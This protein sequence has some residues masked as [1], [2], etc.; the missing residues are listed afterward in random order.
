MSCSNLDNY[1]KCHVKYFMLTPKI[2]RIFS[3]KF[4]MD[5]INFKTLNDCCLKTTYSI[6]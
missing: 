6:D 1:H 3:R 4:S 5:L 2:K